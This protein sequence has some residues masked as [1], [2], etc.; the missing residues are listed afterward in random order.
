MVRSV[1]TDWVDMLGNSFLFR[2]RTL[3]VPGLSSDTRRRACVSLRPP[4]QGVD[5]SPPTAGR[6][7]W[8]F[9]LSASVRH[10]RVVGADGSPC[11]PGSASKFAD[12][13]S[14]LH[15]GLISE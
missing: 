7:G 9:G 2:V 11:S 10:S 12:A 5:C 8:R 3:G 1:S 4:A 13:F 15:V 14:V 6:R